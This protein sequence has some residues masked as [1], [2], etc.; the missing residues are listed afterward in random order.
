MKL[1][2]L[3]LSFSLVVTVSANQTIFEK[4]MQSQNNLKLA[5]VEADRNLTLQKRNQNREIREYRDTARDLRRKA[6]YARV[7]NSYIP[8]R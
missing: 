1:S 2:S 5:K 4:Y 7:E 3:F 8:Y 6:V